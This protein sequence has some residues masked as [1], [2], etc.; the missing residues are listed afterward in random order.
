MLDLYGD[1]RYKIIE[2]L[3]VLRNIAEDRSVSGIDTSASATLERLRENAFN[4]V[5]FGEFKRGKSTFINSLLGKDILPSAV[6]PLTSVVTIVMYGEEEK[7][8]IHFQDGHNETVSVTD[9]PEFITESENPKNIKRVSLVEVL[10]PAELL[11]DGVRL[12]DTPGVGSVYQH[13]TETAREFLPNADAAI[14]LVAADPPISKSER[15]FLGQVKECVPRMFFVQNKMDHL[16]SEEL[17]QSVEFNRKVIEDELGY[18]SVHIFPISARQALRG[19]LQGNPD[20]V[21][22]SRV[23][24]F[25]RTLGRFLMKD[26]GTVALISALNG[27]IKAASDLKVGIE[28]EKKAIE[29]PL[30]TLEERLQLFQERLDFVRKQKDEDLYL[31]EELVRKQVVERLDADL[32]ELHV[33][34]K[35]FLHTRLDQACDEC[36]GR[37]ASA[38]L[39]HINEVMPEIVEEA[40]TAWQRGEIERIWDTLNEKLQQ[41]TDKVNTL[42]DQVHQISEDVFEVS[43]EYFRP[44]QKLGGQSRFF[45]RTWN[46]RVSFEFAVMPLLYILPGR[47]VRRFIENAAWEKLWEQF[48]MHCGQTRY[49]FVQR[50]QSTIHDYAKM[51]DRKIED[52]AEGI[53]SAVRDAMDTK[54]LGREATIA[55]LADLEQQKKRIDNI[56]AELTE[57]HEAVISEDASWGLK[58]AHG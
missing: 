11:R 17:E 47:W 43:L 27:S 45:F 46:I 50:I 20:M 36:A 48:D 54:A 34:R 16:S 40:L 42:I 39:S 30:E 37:R 26:R 14:F 56:L 13:N 21:D 2:S 32:A 31:L 22:E 4:L 44:D 41:F 24:E 49:D 57:M 8:I 6:V 25:E 15:E 29:T 55:S 38:L 9:L 10:E 18:D 58:L 1:Y 52:T 5:V 33:S 7:A 28:L 51:L 19:K 53:E 23:P 35:T 12:I 3:D